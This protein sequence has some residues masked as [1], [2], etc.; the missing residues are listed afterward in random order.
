MTDR[1]MPFAEPAA[2]VVDPAPQAPPKN[3][4][5]KNKAKTQ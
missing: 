4:K 5:Q 1:A 3:A 2:A